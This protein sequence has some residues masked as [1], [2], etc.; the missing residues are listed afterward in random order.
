MLPGTEVHLK[1]LMCKYSVCFAGC[2][3][4]YGIWSSVVRRGPLFAGPLAYHHS[5]G[6][7][8]DCDIE[9]YVV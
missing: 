1:S 5:T 9:A 4:F 3:L 6:P 2:L 8:P 7:S